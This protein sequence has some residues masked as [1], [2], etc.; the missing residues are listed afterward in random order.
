MPSPH[1]LQRSSKRKDASTDQQQ[2]ADNAQELHLN[3]WYT[4]KTKNTEALM[5]NDD[6]DS[7]SAWE[8]KMAQSKTNAFL[9]ISSEWLQLGLVQKQTF[10]GTL[11]SICNSYLQALVKNDW[12]S[13]HRKEPSSYKALTLNTYSWLGF[14]LATKHCCFGP[15]YTVLTTP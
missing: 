13:L 8:R 6:L 2:K 9:A 3:I 5:D 7:N 12:D 14:K 4:I 1:R 10:C 11:T 15:A